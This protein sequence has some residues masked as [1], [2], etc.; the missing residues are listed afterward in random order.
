M[1]KK[2]ILGFSISDLYI[3]IV[4]GLIIGTFYI[5]FVLMSGPEQSTLKDYSESFNDE[6]TLMGILESD[7][8]VDGSNITFMELIIAGEISEKHRTLALDKIVEISKRLFEVTGLKRIIEVKYSERLLITSDGTMEKTHEKASIFLYSDRRNG[9]TVSLKSYEKES[10][11][12]IG[13]LENSFEAHGR[14]WQIWR[15]GLANQGTVIQAYSL[16]GCPCDTKW[17]RYNI[18]VQGT[19]HDDFVVALPAEWETVCIDETI[20][21]FLDGTIFISDGEF[22]EETATNLG[23]CPNE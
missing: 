14:E 6:V 10:P 16:L 22:N 12:S 23:D 19:F 20:P 9:L 13:A 15:H 11:V 21:D 4:F 5:I 3:Y 7:I 8:E 18:H 2:G 1:K 17:K